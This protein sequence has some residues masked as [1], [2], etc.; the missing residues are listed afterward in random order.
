M[1]KNLIK[2]CSSDEIALKSFFLGP[3]AENADFFKQEVGNIL[4]TWINWR[5]ERF[6]SDGDAISQ[7][8]QSAPEFQRKIE[9]FRTQ[10]NT[11]SERFSNEI[12]K[13]SPRYIGHMFSEFSL[14]ALL[15]HFI[16]LLHNPNNVSKESSRVG[17]EIENE[18]IQSLVKMFGYRK[19]AVG[20][21]TSGG[22]VAN[23][24]SVVRAKRKW[25]L[26][27]QSHIDS[28][29]NFNE[30][31]YVRSQTSSQEHAKIS[32]LSD[33]HLA[34]WIEKQF[35]R[36]FNG[37]VMF[38]PTSKH[39]SWTKAAKY[40]GFGVEGLR[41]IPLNKWGQIDTKLLKSA[42]ETCLQEQIPIVSVNSICGS[43]EFG[44]IDPI[45]E[46]QEILDYYK[47]E[48]GYQFW[49]HVDAA[50]GGFFATIKALNDK[51]IG[52]NTKLALTALAHSTSITVDPHKLGY[53]P[54]SSG[55]FICRTAED[56][57]VQETQAPYVDFQNHKDRGPY[58]L[59]GSR[60]AAG[61]VATYMTSSCIGF[62]EQGYGQIIL[63]TIKTC[64]LLKEKLTNSGL[65]VLIIENEMTNILCFAIGQR[66]Q[67]LSKINEQTKNVIK[68]FQDK[69]LAEDKDVFYLS[70]TL[71]SESHEGVLDHFNK[72]FN[73]SVDQN[74][75]N[76]IRLTTMNPFL[77]SVNTKV[78]F[79]DEFI[80]QISLLLKK[81]N[82]QI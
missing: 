5:K 31:S 2:P 66:G 60:S 35:N 43:T 74:E 42:I 70:K 32:E 12:P 55:A 45:H 30:A 3:Q 17:V 15:G 23:F 10:I 36:E 33:I 6:P 11:L 78:N 65:P 51:E 14:P 26:N 56:Y 24:E 29:K 39:Y 52:E 77:N 58:T 47:K 7:A 64:H 21:F 28:K 75:L 63:R 79:I 57:F 61:A 80:K 49:H 16:C 73:I 25:I 27:L 34:R 22:T 71:I 37:A 69:I 46:T 41:Q 50:Y 82:F 4:S 59:E 44:T 18:A 67:Y 81:E 48:Y 20:H 38:V 62:D 68:Q 54:Y 72:S 13:F 76:L 53:V 9:L 8:D 40:F 1:S 19:D